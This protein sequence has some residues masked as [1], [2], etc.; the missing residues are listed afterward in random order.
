MMVALDIYRPDQWHDFFVMVGGGAAVLTG[1]VFVAMSLNVSVITQDAT[2]RYRAIGTLTGI[3]AAF[4]IC[5]LALMGHQD[6]Y[7]VGIEW[8]VVAAIAA[9]VYIYGYI[10]ATRLGGSVAWLRL[11]RVL[12]GTACYLA[13]VVGTGL[14][15]AGQIAGLYIAAVAM[16][17]R[18]AFMISGAWLLIIGVSSRQPKN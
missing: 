1:L 10:Q 9:G 6:H 2:H 15:I 14:V 8:M 18:L 13:E 7:S 4:V 12:S 16:V 11:H 3:T 17:I 5:A